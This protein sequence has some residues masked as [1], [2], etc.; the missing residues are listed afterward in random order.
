MNAGFIG[1]GCLGMGII[2]YLSTL[3]STIS[4]PDRGD[5]LSRTDPHRCGS[6]S[7]KDSGGISGRWTRG[8]PRLR[9]AYLCNRLIPAL[10]GNLRS[11]G[12]S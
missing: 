9:E 5:R 12:T 6:G 1:L 4:S 11:L 2:A 8:F 10:R 7:Y 3:L